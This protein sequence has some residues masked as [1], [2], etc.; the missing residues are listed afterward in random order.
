ML[1]TYNR[2]FEKNMVTVHP[3]EFWISDK[4]MIYTLLGT[5]VAVVLYSEKHKIGGLNH[6]L[7]P[8]PSSVG[9]DMDSESG[10]YGVNAMEL[11][12]NG[13][14]KRG[15]EKRELKAKIFGGGK[16]L[17][18]LPGAANLQHVGE[19]NVDFVESF[20]SKER[21][22]VV[23]GDV[24]GTGG[25]KIYLF[26]DTGKVLLARIKADASLVS[27][28]DKYKKDILTHEHGGDVIFFNK[29]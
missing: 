15:V 28:E 10:R 2:K 20:L 29:D 9:S 11:L 5:C 17:R 13:F 19:K 21:I 8:L 25:R 22:P 27:M 14:L 1:T 6:Y 18:T 16:V 23:A 24:G 7:L 26:P 3:G 12:I 4:D